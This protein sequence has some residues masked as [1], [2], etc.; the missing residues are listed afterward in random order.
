[1]WAGGPWKPGTSSSRLSARGWACGPGAPSSVF[2]SV[3]GFLPLVSLSPLKSRVNNSH[4][5]LESME[6]TQAGQEAGRLSGARRSRPS[7]PLAPHLPT[8]SPSSSFPSFSP[9]LLPRIGHSRIFST[10]GGSADRT[11]VCN[12]C[13]P[14]SHLRGT[15]V[16]SH[17]SCKC[18]RCRMNVLKSLGG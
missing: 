12:D 15:F 14:A 7:L 16:P 2:C 11:A 3:A 9:F 13:G 18:R 17:M 10:S 4:G 6:R 1:M 8:T 5:N